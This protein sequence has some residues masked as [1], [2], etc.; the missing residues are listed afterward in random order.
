MPKIDK[1]EGKGAA[2]SSSCSKAAKKNGNLDTA[3]KKAIND[4]LKG[5]TAQELHG[6]T[7]AG[8][9]TCYQRIA[10]RKRKHLESPD[11]FPLGAKFYKDKW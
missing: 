2:G 1:V 10:E 7:D 11:E 5:M 3:V 4:N 8:G 9:M 6:T